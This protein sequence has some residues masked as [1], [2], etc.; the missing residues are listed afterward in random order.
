V[1]ALG[2]GVEVGGGDSALAAIDDSDRPLLAAAFQTISHPK[3]PSFW[4]GGHDRVGMRDV[5][6]LQDA[7]EEAVFAPAAGSGPIAGWAVVGLW[8]AHG[9]GRPDV[10]E[11]VVL[12][13]TPVRSAAADPVVADPAA[14]PEGVLAG[15]P[16][17][18]A[19]ADGHQL[20]LVGHLART[21]RGG[22]RG[23]AG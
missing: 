8:L 7:V 19:R 6:R 3:V 12:V 2:E 4:A 11:R 10:G 9:E 1:N 13:F 16:G 21:G 17:Q 23:T 15:V 5:G 22:D 18:P 14:L 20:V